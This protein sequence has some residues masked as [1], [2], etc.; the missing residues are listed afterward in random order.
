MQL[1]KQGKEWHAYLVMRAKE[2]AAERYERVTQFVTHY[3]YAPDPNDLRD[4]A[5]ELYD[6]VGGIT[7]TLIA[8]KIKRVG[9]S[10][11]DGPRLRASASSVSSLAAAARRSAASCAGRSLRPESR[12]TGAW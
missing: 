4:T 5:E 2:N 8:A 11:D 1:K 12:G 3:K 7:M 10:S 6:E 9:T